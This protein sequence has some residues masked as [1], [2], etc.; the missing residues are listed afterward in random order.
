M[1]T[2]NQLKYYTSLHRKKNRK[3]ENK[4]LVE[5]KRIVE[6]GLKCD[7]VCE[8]VFLSNSFKVSNPDILKQLINSKIRFELLKEEDFEKLC[9]TKNPQGIAAVF[10]KK[11]IDQK[12]YQHSKIIV[13]LENISDPGNEGTIIRNC[14]WFGIKEIIIGEN[15]VELFNPKVIRSTMGSIFHLNIFE[16]ENLLLKINLLKT[17]G[18]QIV[19]ADINGDNL[20]E[21][22]PSQKSLIIFSSEAF[23]PS[24]EIIKLSD[25]IITIPKK[26]KAESLNIASASAVI[27]SYLSNIK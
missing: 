3:E 12:S 19:C 24:N 18:Y 26:G 2:K 27:L 4:F 17:H 13:A 1:L 15:C 9:L 25:K 23:G 16:E 11:N 22:N 5:G 21:F 14:D 10:Y 6:E 7:Y 20:F 8:L